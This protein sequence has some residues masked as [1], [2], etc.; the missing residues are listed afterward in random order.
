MKQAAWAA[1]MVLAGAMAGM[2]VATAAEPF[3]G[4]YVG[5]GLGQKTTNVEEGVSGGGNSGSLKLGDNSFF[6]QLS[7]GYGLA[8]DGGLRLGLGMFYDV[9]D[10]KAGSAT[11]TVG[12]LN[13]TYSLK[14]T[15]HYGVS[16][17]PG[18]AVTKDAVVYAKLMYNWMKGEETLSGA[19]AG[20]ASKNFSAFGYGAGLKQ[21]LGGGLYLFAEWQ[22]VQY[23]TASFAS[24]ASTISFKPS[25][26]SGLIGLGLQF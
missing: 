20:S 3:T 11:A 7:A 15:R 24:G 8:F 18:Y 17:E 19:T 2:N 10:G 4:F 26:S 5:G 9:G 21:A 6:G 23:D 13:A 12:G 16:L 22:R 25:A 14:E 1:G